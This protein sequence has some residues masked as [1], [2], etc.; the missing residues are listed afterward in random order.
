MVRSGF[1]VGVCVAGLSIAVPSSADTARHRDAADDNHRGGEAADIVSA[2]QGH[3]PNGVLVHTVTVRGELGPREDW[4]YLWL[5]DDQDSPHYVID[6]SYEGG[7][8]IVIESV[9]SAYRTSVRKV[10]AHT[11]RYVFK[12]RWLRQSYRD[13]Y[14]WWARTE[15]GAQPAHDA[16]PDEV[17]LSDHGGGA[18]GF[19]HVLEPSDQLDPC[20]P[21]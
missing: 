15:N 7:S 10:D 18:L 6:P 4:P 17:G 19:R 20:N 21:R 5:D 1:L 16:I 14:C 11:V 9:F 12:R 2:T 8:F 13:K 3:R